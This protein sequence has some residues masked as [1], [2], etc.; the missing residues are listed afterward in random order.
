MDTRLRE[1]TADDARCLGDIFFDALGGIAERHNFPVE[2]PAR[3]HARN[4]VTDMIDDDRF[5]GIVAERDRRIAGCAFLDE[6]GVIVGVGPVV[7]DASVQDAGIGRTMMEEA[8]RRE[9]TRGAAGVRLIQATYHVRSMG[10]Y[11]KLGFEARAPLSV[12]HGTPP[13]VTVAGMS[14]RAATKDD[15][16]A[17]GNVC[18][19]VHGHDR[20]EEL[21]AAIAAGTARV[22]ERPDRISGYATEVGYEGHA[23]GEGNDDM[24]AL[25][26]STETFSGLGVRIPSA[27][28]GLLRWCLQHGL[29]IAQQSIVMT[30]GLYNEPQGAWIPSDRY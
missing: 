12:V 19:Q 30:L 29:K 5:F 8:L 26:S 22:V 28:A 24:I 27:N 21:L 23:V 7:V 14:V 6:R 9:R 11:A 18:T 25:I 1:P 20:N 10:L 3:E 2:F 16:D 17:C 13:R 4:A 15:V